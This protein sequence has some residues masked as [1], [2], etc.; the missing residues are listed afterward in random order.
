MMVQLRGWAALVGCVLGC[1]AISWLRF[2]QVR[3]LRVDDLHLPL[4]ARLWPSIAL[5][6]LAAIFAWRYLLL[7]RSSLSL[8]AIVVGAVALHLAAAP[9]LPL[10]SN[11]IFSNLA[12]GR[13]AALGQNPYAATP[14]ALA[15][16][17]EFRAHVGSLW[18]DTP[19]VYGPI[20]TALSGSV[21]RIQRLWGAL[22]VVEVDDA[23]LQPHCGGYR[24]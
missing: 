18:R 4:L 22:F 6:L 20:V 8:R 3:T 17:D 12:Y 19:S 16:N 11:D 24:L 7:Y 5:G 2:Y 15:T 23:R 13:L 10:T 9:A 21:C 14:R 1:T